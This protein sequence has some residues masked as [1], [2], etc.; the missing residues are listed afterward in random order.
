MGEVCFKRVPTTSRR[1]AKAAAAESGC[2]VFN[3]FACWRAGAVYSRGGIAQVGSKLVC[4]YADKLQR[5][6]L[7]GTEGLLVNFK[8]DDHSYVA[9]LTTGGCA[10]FPAQAPPTGQAGWLA[11]G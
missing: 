5:P 11:V 4:A 9:Q 8:G 1:T 6:L 7:E 10:V 3:L 2:P